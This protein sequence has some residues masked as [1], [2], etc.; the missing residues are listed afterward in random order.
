M[1][2]F[3]FVFVSL[4]VVGLFF[5]TQGPIIVIK[6]KYNYLYKQTYQFLVVSSY[7]SAKFLT[8]LKNGCSIAYLAVI[9]FSGM[10]L[11]IFKSKSRKL[12]RSETILNFSFKSSLGKGPSVFNK[13]L[14]KHI[15]DSSSFR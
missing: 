8:L 4:V 9:L 14:S 13:F 3:L 15:L 10:Y 11:N 2:T 12:S 7:S 1:V 6:Y 5:E